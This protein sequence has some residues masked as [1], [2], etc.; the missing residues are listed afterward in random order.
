MADEKEMLSPE[1]S[2]EKELRSGLYV[3]MM[4]GILTLGEFLVASIAGP[5]IF[6][7]WIVALWKTFLVVKN[8]MHIGSVFSDEESH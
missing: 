3:F 2:R 4:L 5:W 6:I 1:E 8:Y 7:L